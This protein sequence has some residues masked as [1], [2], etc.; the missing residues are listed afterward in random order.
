MKIWKTLFALGVL[1]GCGDLSQTETFDQRGAPSAEQQHE[2]L[3]GANH[4]ADGHQDMRPPRHD[5]DC[6]SHTLHD[7]HDHDDQ[8]YIDTPA[9]PPPQEEAND[10]NAQQPIDEGTPMLVSFR[11]AEGTGN[12]PWN[13]PETRIQLKVGQTLRIIN[14]DT[15]A[16]RLH[17]N[18]RPCAHGPNIPPGGFFDCVLAQTYSE[19]ANGI[20]YDHNAGTSARFYLLV[21]N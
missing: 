5:D 3:T 1:T 11:I 8:E 14:D 18:G 12:A 16:H 7:C 19:A 10:E 6:H 2:D 13:S 9:P 20:L 21:S 17:T 15:V 4:P